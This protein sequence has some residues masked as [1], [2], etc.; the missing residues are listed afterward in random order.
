MILTTERLILREFSA[1][2]WPAVLAYQSNPL[3]LR[4]YEWTSRTPGEVREFV[5]MVLAQQ[6]EAPRCKFQL[7]VVLKATGQLI[8]N[9][10][11]RMRSADAHQADI[12]YE[13]D[14][15]HWGQGY[16]TEAARAIVHFGFT[17]LRLHR[18]SSWCIADN[19]GSARVL[20][21]LGMRQEGRLRENEY[22]K[23]RWW[24]TLLYAI[25]DHE[26]QTQQQLFGTDPREEMLP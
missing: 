25:L 18:I 21:K 1:S 24:D 16:A 17:R 14:P 26:W 8:G 15:Q 13:L 10:G 12:G 7:A 19:V 6:R 9:C 2:D 22:F 11:I 20:E 23:G 4:Y 3:Y 5:E